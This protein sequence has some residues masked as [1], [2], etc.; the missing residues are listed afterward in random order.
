LPTIW[1]RLAEQNVSRGYYFSDVPFLALWGPRYVSISHPIAEFFADC[2]AD[3]LPEVAFV[4]PRFLGEEE[5]A[6]NDD[7]PHAD[8]RNGENFLD[9]IYDAVTSSEAWPNTILVINFDEWGGFFDH[10]PPPRAPVPP[11]DALLG[12]DGLRGF[13]VPTLVISPWSR[14]GVVAHHVYD[15]TS[16]L[17][18]IEWRW[19][20][21]P[22][23]VRDATA[24]IL[25]EVLDFERPNFDSPD[26]TVPEGPFGAL[27][28]PTMAAAKNT[29]AL[30]EIAAELGF[31]M[32]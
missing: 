1:D 32:P 30:A 20:L 10:V 3:T 6:T 5:G 2:A 18:M 15:H 19:R 23:T 21:R 16:V 9:T 14:R 29:A 17:A 7:H 24:N 12:N 31:P 13:R 25:A 8:I 11:A 28:P 4:D 27:C 22:L 26:F